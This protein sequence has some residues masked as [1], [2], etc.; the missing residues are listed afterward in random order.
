MSVGRRPLLQY[1]LSGLSPLCEYSA[2]SA[3]DCSPNV[4]T[5]SARSTDRSQN[6]VALPGPSTQVWH[7]VCLRPMAIMTVRTLESQM[8]G[9]H[10]AK[11]SERRHPGGHS[12]GTVPSRTPEDTGRIRQPREAS[13][14]GCSTGL[15]SASVTSGGPGTRRARQLGVRAGYPTTCDAAPC[16][17]SYAVGCRR[18]WP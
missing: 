9:R 16:A 14:P 4:R 8:P 12:V 11:T 13:S 6:F 5:L 17:T 2:H 7:S 10:P 18:R 15:G 3:P 1:A